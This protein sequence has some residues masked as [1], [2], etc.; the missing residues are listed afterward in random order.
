LKPSNLDEQTRNEIIAS[1]TYLVENIPENILAIV[2]EIIKN[3]EDTS[4]TNLSRITGLTGPKLDRLT[5]LLQ[6]KNIDKDSLLLA[7][8]TAKNIW[9]YSRQDREWVSLTYTGPAQFEVLGR[10]TESVLKEMLDKANDTVTIIGYRITPGAKKIVEALH[11]CIKRGVSI[12]LVMDSD[13]ES[14][15]E[16]VLDNLWENLKKPKVYTRKPAKGDVYFK[17]HAKIIAIDS[18]DLLVTSA[19][20]TYY[21]M[22]K[23]LEV[24][25]RIQGKTGTAEKVEKLVEHLIKTKYLE[26]M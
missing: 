3:T 17:I 16:D 26:E 12:I 5:M 4:S 24:G 8:Q 6:N 25:V 18:V 13:E 19:N 10:H 21:G 15:N 1:L 7:I 9:N 14:R 22:N 23:N 2:E 20:L 11:N